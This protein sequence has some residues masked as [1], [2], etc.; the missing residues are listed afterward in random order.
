MNKSSIG[1]QLVTPSRHGDHRGFFGEIYSRRSYEELGVTSEFVQDNHSL[2][3]ALGTLRGLHFQAPPHARDI[4]LACLQT[5]EQ[6]IQEPSKSSIYHF[7]GTPDV[8][9][10]DFAREIFLSKRGNL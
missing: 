8:S 3:H 1:L 7:S 2:S 5:A 4:A 9:L 6:L 10:A